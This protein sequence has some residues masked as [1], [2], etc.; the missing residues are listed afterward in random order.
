MS[1][2]KLHICNCGCKDIRDIEI[3]VQKGK[4]EL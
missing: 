2:T 4:K 3:N 1:F